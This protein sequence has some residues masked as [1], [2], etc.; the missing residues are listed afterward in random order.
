MKRTIHQPDVQDESSW[1]D[2]RLARLVQEAYGWPISRIMRDQ[3]RYRPHAEVRRSDKRFH[4]VRQLVRRDTAA[5]RRA[6]D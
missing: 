2:A 1:T 4:Q 6:Q 3:A 5:R